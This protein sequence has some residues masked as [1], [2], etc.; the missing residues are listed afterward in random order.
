M[1]N[2]K[3]RIWDRQ[4]KRFV[5]NK[6]IPYRESIWVVNAF[7]GE[8]VNFVKVTNGHSSP[9]TDLFTAELNPAGYIDNS[10]VIGESRF[11]LS[12]YTG[13]KDK[14]SK[15]VYE[16][17]LISFTYRAK[18]TE[19]EKA[20]ADKSFIGRVVRGNLTTNLTL[21]VIEPCGISHYPLTS[22]D[23]GKVEIIGNIF[24]KFSP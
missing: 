8:L 10:R 4:N 9:N 20:Q 11:V 24:E 22:A 19:Y 21:E 12:S 6:F 7:S 1:S 14:H 23:D 17:D 2:L 13:L 3:F 16:G 18:E 5:D 15:E